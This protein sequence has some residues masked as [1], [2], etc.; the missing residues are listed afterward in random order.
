VVVTVKDADEPTIA[1]DAGLKEQL[2]S[3]GSP[4]QERTKLPDKLLPELETGTVAAP[5]LTTLTDGVTVSVKSGLAIVTVSMPLLA[6]SQLAS[7][8]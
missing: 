1:R 2:A 7:P 3:A 4:E 6:V 5:P 8:E